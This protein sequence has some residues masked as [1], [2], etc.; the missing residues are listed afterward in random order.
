MADLKNCPTMQWLIDQE[1]EEMERRKHDSET[2]R[3]KM[4]LTIK[5]HK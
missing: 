3:Y 2:Q 1:L 4:A 5:H